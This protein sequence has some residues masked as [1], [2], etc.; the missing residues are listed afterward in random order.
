MT[1][2]EDMEMLYCEDC[3]KRIIPVVITEYQGERPH[4]G[5]ISWMEC[6][7]C[8]GGRLADWTTCGECMEPIAEDNEYCENCIAKVEAEIRVFLKGLFVKYD[9][10]LINVALAKILD[11]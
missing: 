7:I 8:S 10:E 9:E 11:A 6:P 1:T 3:E 4:G 2:E 5:D